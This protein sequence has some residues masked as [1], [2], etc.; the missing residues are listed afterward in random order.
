MTRAFVDASVLFAAAKSETGASR[1]IVRLAIQGEVRLVA[2]Q[3]VLEEVRR[4]LKAKAPEAVAAL[5]DFLNAVS[6]DLVRPTKSEVKAAMKYVAAKDAAPIIAAA[7][8]AQVDFLVSLDRR[9]IVGV[10]E[11]EKRS[12]LNIVLPA[13]LL[14]EIRK[15]TST[16]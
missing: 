16:G 10:P 12:G 2:S 3:F 8:R 6:F 13:D 9:H 5:D 1:E 4:N 15:R 11:V 7:K 14:E